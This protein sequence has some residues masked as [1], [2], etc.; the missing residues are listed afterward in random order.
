M[1]GDAALV[2]YAR[3]CQVVDGVP[4]TK[5][6]GV[7]V[8]GEGAPRVLR[9]PTGSTE[10]Y[11]AFQFRDRSAEGHTPL[12]QNSKFWSELWGVGVNCGG[13]VVSGIGVVGAVGL[14]PETGGMSLP[15]AAL[16]AS[17]AGAAVAQ[18]G[19]SLYRTTAVI[20][21][22][23]DALDRLDEKPAYKYSMWVLD[24]V[25]LLGAGSAVKEMMATGGALKSAGAS[26]STTQSLSRQQRLAF[27][28][29]IEIEGMKRLPSGTISR[30]VKQRLLDL[31]VA[32]FGMAGSATIDGGI[33]YDV[34]IWLVTQPEKR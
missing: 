18:C 31:T 10:A 7:V 23:E 13:A 12:M 20:R 22:R 5:G 19:V 8:A 26:W 2:D 3:L 28:S 29:A 11:V 14:A 21:G 25:G 30:I 34:A 24:G 17:G 1:R 9:K 32:A 16:M 33:T 27:T 15:A 6:M 4:E